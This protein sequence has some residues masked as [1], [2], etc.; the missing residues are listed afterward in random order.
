MSASQEHFEL[1]LLLA[2][3]GIVFLSPMLVFT[4]LER[5]R[6]NFKVHLHECE[7]CGA[8]NRLTAS[9]CY[10]CGQLLA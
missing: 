5:R 1:I 4:Y 9:R 7:S 3:V 10:C 6:P 8:D 2:S